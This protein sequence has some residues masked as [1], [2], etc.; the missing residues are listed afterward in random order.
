MA[1][2]ATADMGGTA[3]TIHM[4]NDWELPVEEFSGRIPAGVE[5]IK[6]LREHAA[7]RGV[8][9]C[10][11][12]LPLVW[13]FGAL[14]LEIIR[15]TADWDDVKVCLDSCH[16]TMSDHDTAALVRELAPRVT[17]THFSDTMGDDD[18]HL[19]PG[20]GNVDYSM[21]TAELGKAGFCGV[22]DLECSLWMLRKRHDQKRTHQGDPAPCSTEH[23]LAKAFSAAKRIGEQIEQ[24]KTAGAAG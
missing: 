15:A 24:V 14:S 22:V 20:E 21:V 13:N 3:I 4:A 5:S 7:T 2:D 12:N 16:A 10:I 19:I 9:V 17:A 6:E 1:L 8:T 23:Y 11:E 18:S